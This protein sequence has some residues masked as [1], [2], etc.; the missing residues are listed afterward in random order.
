[1]GFSTCSGP[2]T[3]VPVAFHA[4]RPLVPKHHLGR[5]K[6]GSCLTRRV[7][8][9]SPKRSSWRFR[10]GLVAFLRTTD[11][12]IRCPSTRPGESAPERAALHPRARSGAPRAGAGPPRPATA[13]S[14]VDPCDC[15]AGLLPGPSEDGPGSTVGRA[16]IDAGLVRPPERPFIASR[17][18][19]DR[20]PLSRR[21]FDGALHRGAVSRSSV[22][23]EVS[24]DT[25][26]SRSSLPKL[27]SGVFA[28]H[29]PGPGRRS[30]RD[31][32]HGVATLARCDA[33]VL[34][35][36]PR[37]HFEP[38]GF[39]G[40]RVLRWRPGAGSRSEPRAVSEPRLREDEPLSG[41]RNRS[42]ASPLAGSV[43]WLDWTSQSS[44]RAEP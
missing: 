8:T 15:S 31:L 33:Q 2:R 12:S 24:R 17:R 16:V 32:E 22:R 26:S 36:L 19:V 9:A 25:P 28:D 11:A 41:G 10:A 4:S 7:G 35:A 29:S 6:R 20:A 34:P 37:V 27:D 40:T 18:I 43:L 38:C 42:F 23:F 1:M 5:G 3:H 13:P 44:P 14:H 21:S 30:T 39:S